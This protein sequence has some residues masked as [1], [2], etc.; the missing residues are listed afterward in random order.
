MLELQFGNQF[1]FEER[2]LE[3]EEIIS[4]SSSMK[5][6]LSEM[7]WIN[8]NYFPTLIMGKTGSGKELI[9]R[10]LFRTHFNKTHSFL[11]VTVGV[12]NA[13]QVDEH[14]FDGKEYPVKDFLSKFVGNTVFIKGLE[15]MNCS[16]QLKLLRVLKSSEYKA[17]EKSLEIRLIC[18][19]H[20][21]L[22]EKIKEDLFYEELFGQFSRHLLCVP[23]LRERIQD[24]PNL[25]YYYLSKN[26]FKGSVD[27]LVFNVL[28]NYPWRGNVAELKDLCDR[29]AAVS[30]NK[31]SIKVADLPLNIRACGDL[32]LFIKYNP[33]V[34][35]EK[36]KNWY[37]KLAIDHFQCKKRAAQALG[38]SV[39]TIYNKKMEGSY[40]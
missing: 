13:S 30:L 7:E 40:L 37:I 22:L 14:L 36:I 4:E 17:L 15:N 20:T 21:D 8:K 9:A 16:T 5:T 31:E 24:I 39:K 27:P 32:P 33:K 3:N 2:T 11:K 10:E 19:A 12:A 23:D 1:V 18:T 26:N 35:L 28:K 6:I 25:F 29:L 34:D 38:I